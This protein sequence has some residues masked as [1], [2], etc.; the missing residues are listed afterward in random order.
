MAPLEVLVVGATGYIGGTILSHLAVET[1][2]YCLTAVVRR[3]QDAETLESHY[4]SRVTA[5]TI[6]SFATEKLVQAAQ[7]ADV[8]IYACRNTQDGVDELMRGLADDHRVQASDSHVRKKLFIMLSAIISVVNPRNMQLGELSGRVYS[9]VED[10]GHIMNLPESN[11]HVRQ[12]QD[13]LRKTLEFGI[14]GVIMSLPFALGNGTGSVRRMSF[15]HQ[16]VK[17]TSEVGRPF[18]LGKGLNR[19]SWC[20]VRDIARAVAI[21]IVEIRAGNAG[22][23]PYY[24]YVETG[25]FAVREEALAIGKMLGLGHEDDILHFDYDQFKEFMPELPALWGVSCRVKADRLRNAGWEPKDKDWRAQLDN[26][27]ETLF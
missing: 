18:V 19:W 2:G 3:Q 25:E 23:R 20:S 6:E 26:I 27:R 12:E 16:Y 1:S 21:L 14:T 24:Y 10:A 15:A 13:F 5:I 8:V 7:F 11:W 4:S 22:S 17:V 9:D